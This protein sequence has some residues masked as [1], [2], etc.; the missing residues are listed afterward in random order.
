[1]VHRTFSQIFKN[2]ET[3]RERKRE[4]TVGF[5]T[6]KV[7]HLSTNATDYQDYAIPAFYNPFLQEITHTPPA[8][9]NIPM[10]DISCQTGTGQDAKVSDSLS[11]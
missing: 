1:M 2:M 8:C 5:L 7:L 9:A 4:R 11:L 3:L 6:Y 10:A